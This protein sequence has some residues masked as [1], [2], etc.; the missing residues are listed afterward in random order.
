MLYSFLIRNP[1]HQDFTIVM[2]HPKELNW[3][4]FNCLVEQAIA[5]CKNLSGFNTRG[6]VM[7]AQNLSR[8]GFTIP[9][10]VTGEYLV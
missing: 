2:E 7:V 4:G 3:P 9:P 10:M 5:E 8:F 6:D 1:Y